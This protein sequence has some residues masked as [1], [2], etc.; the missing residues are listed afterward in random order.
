MS[1]LTVDFTQI[2][3]QLLEPKLEEGQTEKPTCVVFLH[4][5]VMDNLSSWFFT[6]A[7]PVAQFTRA[8]VYDLRG[9]GFSARPKTGYGIATHLNDLKELIE[10]VVG[11]EKVILVGNSYGGLL[12]LNFAS[13]HPEL[14]AGLV[15]IDAQIND[16]AWKQQMLST[17]SLQGEERDRVI[18]EN[19]D[20]WLGRRSLRKSRR[21]EE[22]AKDLLY[23]TSLMDD[24]RN[25]SYLVDNDLHKITVP[26]FAMYG[27]E[28]DI[29]ATA[30]QL[31]T[32]MPNCHLQIVE[33][34]THSV[35]WEQTERVKAWIIDSIQTLIDES[36]ETQFLPASSLGPI[37]L[38]W[39]IP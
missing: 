11:G 16:E 14:V 7:N 5:F 6:L 8:L 30:H 26:C 36:K 31:E 35:L 9:H 29:L 13:K 28:S 39:E 10:N 1:F 22:N 4:G 3:Y 19:F 18:I 24:L 23:H 17:F 27:G 15:L 2:H 25:E 34:S 33:G 21:L 38:E 20:N 12:A 37:S 32:V